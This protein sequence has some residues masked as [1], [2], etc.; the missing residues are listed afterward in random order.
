LLSGYAARRAASTLR[1]PSRTFQTRVSPGARRGGL[2]QTLA[3][4]ALDSRVIT[5]GRSL[6]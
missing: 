2:H 6:F 1:A 5:D 3:P 4:L